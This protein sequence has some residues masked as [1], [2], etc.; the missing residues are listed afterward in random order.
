MEIF[1]LI[2]ICALFIFVVVGIVY[3]VIINN[4]YLSR[5]KEQQRQKE[6]HEQKEFQAMIENLQANKVIGDKN[7]WIAFKK[8]NIIISKRLISL[9]NCAYYHGK[10]DTIMLL[11]DPYDSIDFEDFDNKQRQEII[12]YLDKYN[13]SQ[14]QTYFKITDK[15]G[16]VDKSNFNHGYEYAYMVNTGE[17]FFQISGSK[18]PNLKWKLTNVEFTPHYVTDYEVT[19]KS[20]ETG[21]VGGH[22]GA[23][24]IGGLIGGTTGAVIGSS[25]GREI[26]STTVSYSSNSAQEREVP[27]TALITIES[28]DGDKVKIA[29]Q[30]YEDDIIILKKYFLVENETREESNQNNSNF[31]AELQKLKKMM[32]EGLLTE[33]EFKQ[34]KK[35]LL[36]G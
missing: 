26:N 36:E 9:D 35:K 1:W 13:V 27:S 10:D 17:K 8:N 24:T 23:A 4:R 18:N 21:R 6:I 7:N 19:T 28:S 33:E 11:P 32:D 29:E 5:K 12:D 14:I 30:Y 2:F 20:E 16:L 22:A 31:V 34:G 25:L 15:S 3:S